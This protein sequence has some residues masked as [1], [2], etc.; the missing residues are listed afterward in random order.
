MMF[1]RDVA[2]RQ[3]EMK[4]SKKFLSPYISEPRQVGLTLSVDGWFS[5]KTS[6]NHFNSFLIRGVVDPFLQILIVFKIIFVG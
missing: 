1:C 3:P 2:R 4:G 6:V 5:R